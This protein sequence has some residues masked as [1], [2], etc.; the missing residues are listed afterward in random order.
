MTAVCEETAGGVVTGQHHRLRTTVPGGT[1][2][3]DSTAENGVDSVTGVATGCSRCALVPVGPTNY[4]RDGRRQLHRFQHAGPPNGTS[5]LV[6]QVAALTLNGESDCA[7]A[8]TGQ[9]Q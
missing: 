3:V 9:R 8:A 1:A 4:A 6:G 7:F 5:A 2:D